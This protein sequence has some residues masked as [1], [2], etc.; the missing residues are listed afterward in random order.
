MPFKFL[1]AAALGLAVSQPAAAATI[2]D[3]N[4]YANGDV[5]ISGGSYGDIASD[6]LTSPTTHSYESWTSSSSDLG[7]AA[8][9]LSAQ[10]KG[11]APTGSMTSAQWEPGR[12]TLTGTSAGINVFNI[13]GSGGTAPWSVIQNLTFSGPGTGAIVNVAGTSLAGHITFNFNGM[14]A[15]QVIFNFYEA[16]NVS[17]S[18]MNVNGSIL[19]PSA[20]VSLSGSTIMGS[21]IADRFTAAGATVGGQGFSGHA[22]PGAVPEPST[23]AMLILG[24]GA[25]GA[26]MRRRRAGFAAR[27]LH[28]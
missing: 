2:F 16:N 27:P 19:A 14:A 12:V 10:L 7:A 9:G 24:F 20:L 17:M 6:R 15:D 22:S 25:V 23:W 18:G 1:F 21:V 26:A 11:L 3:Y 8:S 4:V 5:T 13:D 28:A